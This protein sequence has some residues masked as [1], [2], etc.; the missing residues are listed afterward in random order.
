[1]RFISAINGQVFSH[2]R[3]KEEIMEFEKITEEMKKT[4]KK[5]F[6]NFE[7]NVPSAIESVFLPNVI[8]EIGSLYICKHTNL[9]NVRSVF[10]L[11]KENY[12]REICD[13][14]TFSDPSAIYLFVIRL[15]NPG[16]N[17]SNKFRYVGFIEVNDD[18]IQLAWLHPFL[19]NQGLMKTFLIWY[20]TNENCLII[21]PP[22]HRSIERCINSAFKVINGDPIYSKQNID[23][24][25]K[26]L[27]KKS[28]QAKLDQIPDEN[29]NSVLKSIELF[30]AMKERGKDPSFKELEIEEMIAM[31]V[32]LIIMFNS[33]PQFKEYM[34]E[35]AKNHS[36]ELE[37]MFDLL[38]DFKKYG[39][40]EIV[41]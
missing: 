34:T 33:D 7:I 28:P 19:R 11:L 25:R 18:I 3:I 26:Y 2:Q 32:E 4:H 1:V 20:A 9:N 8:R 27:R 41:T 23:M 39:K 30:S 14:T 38:N 15:L 10:N 29:I 37:N 16:L 40:H 22:V 35:Y 36:D 21:Q 24:C 12:E 13:L 17:P 6:T 31:N 5:T